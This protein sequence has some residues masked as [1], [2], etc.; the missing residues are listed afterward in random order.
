MRSGRLSMLAPA[1][2]AR[3]V[4]DIPKHGKRDCVGGRW[5]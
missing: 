4:T 5:T 1:A 3:Y 2:G